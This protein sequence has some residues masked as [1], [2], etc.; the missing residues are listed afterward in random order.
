MN[1]R[2]TI[3]GAVVAAVGLIAFP[4]VSHAGPL[5]EHRSAAHVAEHG[6]MKA[7][8]VWHVAHGQLPTCDEESHEEQ[9]HDNDDRGPRRDHFGFHCTWRGCG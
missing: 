3:A 4:G 6:G 2:I 8:N 5:C 9:R 7:D 1:G